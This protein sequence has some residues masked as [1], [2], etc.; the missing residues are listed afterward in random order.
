MVG[1][2]LENRYR[3]ETLLAQG[4]S[5]RV[6][7]GFDAVSGLAVAVKVTRFQ[8]GTL[9]YSKLK[10]EVAAI[11]SV[12][13]SGVVRLYSHG[14]MGDS[15]YIVMEFVDGPS[16]EGY[17]SSRAAVDVR[18][19]VN[20]CLEIAEA[21][22]CI[23][24]AG[25]IHCDLKPSNVLFARRGD[26]RIKVADFGLASLINIGERYSTPSLAGSFFYMAP[27]QTG[28]LR[29]VTLDHRA[30][31]YALGVMM[32]ELLT[33]RRPFQGSDPAT[34]I[35]Q[36]VSREPMPPRLV[37]SAIPPVLEAIVSKLLRKSPLD[38]YQAAETLIADLQ[39]F[40]D[41]VNQ[42]HQDIQFEIGRRDKMVW[43]VSFQS[44]MVGRSAEIGLLERAFLLGRSGKGSLIVI[45]GEP[46]IGKSRLANELRPTVNRER[47]IFL[48]GKCN[49]YS[50]SFPY[51]PFVEA[52]EQFLAQIT[53]LPSEVQAEVRERIKR[54]GNV[55]PEITRLA[56]AMEELFPG[57]QRM[58]TSAWEAD[59]HVERFLA[60]VSEFFVGLGT[61]EMPLV[62]FLDDLQW[63]DGGTMQLL[64]RIIPK[65][66]NAHVLVV[67]TCREGEVRDDHVI[68]RFRN[69]WSDSISEIRL[70]PLKGREVTGLLCDFLRMSENQALEIGSILWEM[71]GGNPFFVWESLKAWRETGTLV[72]EAGQWRMREGKTLRVTG[73]ARVDEVIAQRLSHLDEQSA[74]ILGYAAVIG[75]RFR[76]EEVTSILP[77]G[78][79]AFPDPVFEALDQ[80]LNHSIITSYQETPGQA[81]YTFVH[82]KVLETL[83]A[84]IPAESRQRLHRLIGET[85]EQRSEDICHDNVFDL[86]LHFDR[87]GDEARALKYA[88]LAGDFA[89]QAYANS[90]AERYYER[91]LM[92]FA[93]GAAVEGEDPCT[94]VRRVREC[95]GDVYCLLGK[96]DD[97]AEQYVKIR[98]SFSDAVDISRLETKLGMVCFRQGYADQ[99]L[100][101]F[102]AGLLALGI[103]QPRTVWGVMLSIVTE[104]IRQIGHTYMPRLFVNQRRGSPRDLEALRLFELLIYFYYFLD[105]KRCFQIHLKQLNL[106]ESIENLTHCRI[107]YGLHELLCNAVGLHTRALRYAFKALKLEEQGS[108]QREGASLGIGDSALLAIGR[109][110]YYAADW[111]HAIEYLQKAV[112]QTRRQGSLWETEVAYGH[113]A[114]AYFG[115]GQFDQVLE[116]ARELGVIAET[117]RDRR[118][119][120]W[121]EVLFALGF[122]H[123]GYVNDALIHAKKAVAHLDAAGDRLVTAMALRVLAQVH[124]K[125]NDVENALVAGE[126]SL[127]TITQFQILHDFITGTYLILA[128]AS[129]EAANLWPAQK[130][131][132]LARARWYVR[133]ALLLS[134]LFKNWRAFAYR[135]RGIYGCR[136]GAFS[137]AAASFD[138]AIEIAERQGARY[139]VAQAYL[140]FGQCLVERKSGGS[141]M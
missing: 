136:T 88:C 112:A 92:L 28:V 75:R 56:P 81:E 55:A 58:S 64:E 40:Q 87:G 123:Q 114:I 7:K 13:H 54:M 41:S 44:R 79:Q 49:E 116:C 59:K 61:T 82:D 130:K 19:A 137:K 12:K 71:T 105:M 78:L 109:A 53:G 36:H 83:Y 8:G 111:D 106:A 126:E 113:M 2:V 110:Y 108:S 15:C 26:R 94:S 21:L 77:S 35:P 14:R 131:H 29:D 69:L 18:E 103:H 91:A 46:G 45:W 66:A 16:L 39:A 85:L 140:A 51:S 72:L 135:V 102:R 119:M 25:I 65:L 34:I 23:H 68:H 138:R 67:G 48:S 9:W 89:K 117:V 133:A 43:P 118:G 57:Y 37:N 27:E 120:G 124:L 107:A 99:T 62:L 90:E 30:D 50:C 141:S 74:D 24:G 17:L 128:E 20:I 6:Y 104:S 22:A 1:Q 63:A 33:G 95:L 97:A 101:H 70:R 122:S 10:R 38:R 127:K 86:A 42:G 139:E 96:Y 73:P 134:L 121:A 115:K 11:S 4:G 100:D 125:N 84:R 98:S 60:S 3:I 32:Y 129:I 80:A 76:L 47:G 5:S 93:N 52:L 31:L 132:Y